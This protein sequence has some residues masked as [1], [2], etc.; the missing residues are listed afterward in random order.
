[1]KFGPLAVA[2][3]CPPLESEP[4]D[5]QPLV[6]AAVAAKIRLVKVDEFERTGARA[7]LNVGHTVGHAL[8]RA[9]GFTTHVHGEAVAI[10]TIAELEATQRLGLTPSSVVSDARAMLERFELP[11]TIPSHLREA[12][13]AHLSSDKKRSGETIL[14]PIVRG[15][16][17]STLERMPLAT[18]ADALK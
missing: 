13:R 10:G 2:V 15:I 16:G 1:M 17:E 7:L 14:F 8:E 18:L 12:T 4:S 9:G 6:L 5:M 3:N 11:T